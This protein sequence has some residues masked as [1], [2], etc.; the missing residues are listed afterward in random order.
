MK[1]ASKPGIMGIS[2]EKVKGRKTSRVAAANQ[3]LG[4]GV[5]KASVK[6]ST[7]ESGP[8]SMKTS[9]IDL[10]NVNTLEECHEAL[11]KTNDDFTKSEILGKVVIHLKS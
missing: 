6:G 7:V 9:L 11:K 3:K 8:T 4:K 5:R 1:G 2:I 10:S